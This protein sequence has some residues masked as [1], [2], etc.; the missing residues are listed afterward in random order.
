MPYCPPPSFMRGRLFAPASRRR[1]EAAP[2]HIF[3]MPALRWAKRSQRRSCPM[4]GAASTPSMAQGRR[5]QHRALIFYAWERQQAYPL[6]DGT[7]RHRRALPRSVRPLLQERIQGGSVVHQGIIAFLNRTQGY[8]DQISD[9]TLELAV[10]FASKIR[11]DLLLTL[12]RQCLIDRQQIRDAGLG[13][14]R[15]K[16]N[17]SLGIRDRAPDARPDGIRIRNGNSGEVWDGA[18]SNTSPK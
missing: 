11:F 3:G 13:R 10:A 9:C 6:L 2:S 1:S 8:D 7:Q 4:R 16:T 14:F 5:Q 12:P 18:F 17:L 15:T